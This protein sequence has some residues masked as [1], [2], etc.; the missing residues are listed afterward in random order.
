[1]KLMITGA[2][3]QVGRELALDAE[4]YGFTPLAVTRSQLDITDSEAV[5]C[6]IARLQPH[7]IINAAGFTD[8]DGAEKEPEAALASNRD[9]PENLA[10]AAAQNAIPLLHLSTDFVFDGRQSTPY[11][12][13]DRTNPLSHYGKSKW[14]GEEAVRNHLNEHIILR[15]SW[16][17]GRF[18][19]NFFC[20]VPQWLQEK[21]EMKVVGDQVGGPTPAGAVSQALLTLAQRAVLGKS[22]SFP[23]GTYHF[24]GRPAVSRYEY[25]QF[26]AEELKKQGI[27]SARRL[28]PVP[29]ATF[30]MPAQ[31]PAYSPMDSRLLEQTFGIPAP[32]WR[33]AAR[34]LIQPID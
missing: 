3:G 31:R 10:R 21:E 34:K 4:G 9:G 5:L 14:L 29:A 24:S 1:M 27:Q 23:W 6:T 30:P 7:I 32:S 17:F 33:E 20:N 19:R 16:V 11:Q 22:A 15:I 18:G 8:V 13:T 28:T 25:S 2:G 12:E 26:I